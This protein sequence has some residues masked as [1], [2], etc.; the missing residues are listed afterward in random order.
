MRKAKKKKK[1]G[2]LLWKKSKNY[3]KNTNM[4]LMKKTRKEVQNGKE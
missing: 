4:N 3:T 1:G 2:S